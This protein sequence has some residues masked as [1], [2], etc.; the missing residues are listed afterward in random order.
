V[1]LHGLPDR[2]VEH[3]TLAELRRRYGLDEAGILQRLQEE[4]EQEV[5]AGRDS[6]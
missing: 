5:G 3:G 6:P 4:L 1:A 2:F